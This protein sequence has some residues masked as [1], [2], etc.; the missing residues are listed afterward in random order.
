MAFVEPNSILPYLGLRPDSFVADFGAG[1]GAYSLLMSRAVLPNG[2]VYAID[3][4]KE[5][6]INLKNTIQSNH[7][8]NI[9]LLWGDLEKLGGT[10]LGDHMID[11]VLIS[12]V[13][14]QTKAGYQIA[15]EAK[16]VLKPEGR[17]GIID[18]TDSFGNMG[19]SSDMIIPEAEAKKIF[20]SAGFVFQKSFPAGDHHY[21]VILKKS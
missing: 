18:W 21:G 19:P 20:E 2:K 4:Q 3:V 13:L 8:T 5:L 15:L 11:F 16:R 17:V 10:K 12:N 6:L 14:F 1:T 7:I 9:E